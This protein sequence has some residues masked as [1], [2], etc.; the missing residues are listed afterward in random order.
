VQDGFTAKGGGMGFFHSREGPHPKAEAQN[1]HGFMNNE[2]LFQRVLGAMVAAC[3]LLFCAG[4]VQA[5]SITVYI[6]PDQIFYNQETFSMS[7]QG[8]FTHDNIDPDY[9]LYM[10]W[11]DVERGYLVSSTVVVTEGADTLLTGT[12][13]SG[14]SNHPKP[15]KDWVLTYYVTGGSQAKDVIGYIRYTYTASGDNILTWTVVP[16]RAST[17]TLLIAAFL[18]LA[19]FHAG[20]RRPRIGR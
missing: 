9:Y 15:G 1:P 11:D 13:S 12:L 3:A 5:K 6:P 16:D 4:I 10:E 18:I 17:L 8:A 2:R 14:T 19:G 7:A 20:T